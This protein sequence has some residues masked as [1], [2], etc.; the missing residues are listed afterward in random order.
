M[1]A[2]RGPDRS[3]RPGAALGR[4]DGAARDAKPA[5]SIDTALAFKLGNPSMKRIIGAA[6][7]AAGLA[8][9]AQAADVGVSIQFSQPGVFGRVDIGQYP[10]PQLIVAQPLMVE[11]PPRGAPPPE[12]IY[13]WVPL[14][15][16]RHWEQHCREYHACGHPVYFVNHVWYKNNVMARQGRPE[17]RHEDDRRREHGRPEEARA[18]ERGH[19]G[20]DQNK[21][22]DDRHDRGRE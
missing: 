15:H 17:G 22:E 14:E 21:H 2:V 3:L 5:R 9:G 13:L 1:T 4:K 20:H 8:A 11:P 18:P 6:L 16:R 19:D 7:C 12:P 10:Q